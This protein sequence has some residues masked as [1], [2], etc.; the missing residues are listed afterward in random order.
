MLEKG[1]TYIHEH[2]YIDLSK[3]KNSDD[4]LL[5]D[6]ETMISELR[7]IKEKGV[8]NIVEV[9]NIGM[10]R[11]M[12]YMEDIRKQT[13]LN[14]I[15]STGFYI[16]P[17]FPETVFQKTDKELAQIMIN[18]IKNGIDGTGIKPEVIGEIGSSQNIITETE[19][20]L[21]Q[22]AGIAQNETGKVLSTH[23]SIGS[24]GLEQIK[25]LKEYS[26]N[27]EKVIIGHTDLSN[28][29][30]YMLRLLDY[31]VYTAFDTIGKNSYLLDEKRAEA[32]KE[33]IKR[34]YGDKIVLSMDITR[35]SHFK[36]N[37]GLGYSHLLDTFVPMMEKA[38]IS[39]ADI[40]KMLITNP[41]NI[42][43]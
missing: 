20:K 42:F 36:K 25:I 39:K 15:Y 35:K 13:G 23:T 21:F 12:E 8:R 43:S 37:G 16:E 31:G 4:T 38:G 22:A 5:D 18:E 11:N 2:I 6:K 28:D 34:G 17:F 3:I 30:D 24:M 7:E 27:F 14:F 9:T 40:N 32:I 26:V 19:K 10:G 29:L 33:L 1:I 41:E